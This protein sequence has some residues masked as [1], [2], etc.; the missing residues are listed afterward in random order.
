MNKNKD[1]QVLSML[2]GLVALFIF[3]A[4]GI[5]LLLSFVDAIDGKTD[6]QGKLAGDLRAEAK[7]RAGRSLNVK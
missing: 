4:G 7:Y 6:D 1:A 5:L 3:T 2:A